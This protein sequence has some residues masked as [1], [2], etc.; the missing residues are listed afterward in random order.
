MSNKVSFFQV[1]NNENEQKKLLINNNLYKLKDR[2]IKVIF[3]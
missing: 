2:V 3:N 1:L